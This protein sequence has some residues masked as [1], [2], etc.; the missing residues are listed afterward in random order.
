M[1][2]L[3]LLKSNYRCEIITSLLVK[4]KELPMFRV[5]HNIVYNSKC[6]YKMS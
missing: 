5:L 3:K 6:N 2:S 4:F 1:N